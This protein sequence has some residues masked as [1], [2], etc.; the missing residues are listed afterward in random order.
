MNAVPP[1]EA[2]R[3]VALDAAG[4]HAEAKAQTG[5]SDFGADDYR[6]GMDVFLEALEREADLTLLGRM[7]AHAYV[8]KLLAGRLRVEATIA[9]DPSILERPLERPVVIVGLPRTGTSH[10][11][12]LLSVHPELRFLPYW[13]ACEPI[14]AADDVARPAGPIRGSSGSR[15]P[16]IRGRR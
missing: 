2:R 7:T 15:R 12:N 11:H 5:L 4:L 16:S 8:V 6:E 14:P 10:L 13:E 3:R 1:E 9:R